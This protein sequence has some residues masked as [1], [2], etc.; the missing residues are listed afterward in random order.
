MNKPENK[1][2]MGMPSLRQ[3]QSMADKLRIHSVKS[4]TKAGSGHPTTCLSCAEIMSCLFFSEIKSHDEFIMS[5]GHAAPILYAAYAEAGLIPRKELMNLRKITSN[6]EGHPI[7]PLVKIATGSLGQGLAAGA[8]MAIA[9]KIKKSSGRV[10][11]LLGDG[12]CAEGSVWEAANMASYYS[13]NNLC[14]I[15]D[16]NRLGQSQQTMHGYNLQAYCKKFSAFGWDAKIVNGHD[17]AEILSALKSAKKSRK[18]FAILAKTIKGKGVSFLENKNGLHGKTIPPDELQAALSELGSPDVKLKSKYRLHKTKYEPIMMPKTDRYKKDE[19]ISTR[20]AFGRALV[21]LGKKNKSIVVLDGDV[22]N[23]TMTEYFF[24]KFSKR[25]FESFI[26]E[27]AMTGAA[28]GLSAQGL[29]P[30]EATFSAFLTR[31]HDFIRMA[32]YSRSNIKFIGSHAGV[33]VGED[34]PSQMG[35]EDMPMFLSIPESVVLYPCDAVSAEKLTIEMAKHTG[36]S[37]LRTTRE[38]TRVVYNNEK[39]PIGKF[40]VLRKSNNDRALII[41]AGITVSEALKAYEILK[42]KKI[43]IR[44]I[45]LYSIKPLDKKNL[46]RHARKCRNNVIVAE[47]HYQCGISCA[48]SETVKAELLYVKDIPRSGKPEQLRKK[49]GIDAHAIISAVL[50]LIRK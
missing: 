3:L 33:S 17:I 10:Y 29:I 45:D 18:P 39:F 40:K 37:Y 13:L 43:N 1:E 9:K 36:I 23:S 12:E 4:T 48:V 20:E 34:G 16:V 32:A 14:A 30:F 19:M 28:M 25:A 50:R 49:Y 6:L 41:A 47:D 26:A 8:G 22:K 11:V 44:V 21:N 46:V 7:Q 31:A 42:N 38:K 15:I 27:Q 35:L 5:K 2:V 24:K